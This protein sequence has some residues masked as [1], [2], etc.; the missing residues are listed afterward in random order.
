MRIALVVAPPIYAHAGGSSPPPANSARETFAR[1]GVRATELPTVRE[2]G[3]L[4]AGAAAQIGRGDTVV[5][6]VSGV[7]V[8]SG[9][10]I[11]LRLAADDEH[12]L[13]PLRALA[14]TVFARAPDDALFVVDARHDGPA[15][16]A[17]FAAEHVDAIATALD[18]R[19]RG[20]S[21][22]VGV[23][24][25]AASITAPNLWPFTRYVLRALEEPSARDDAGA[26][27]IS[28]VYRRVREM[29]ETST[30]VQSF[31]LV[32]GGIDFVV[33]DPPRAH[34][35]MPPAS[36]SISQR[37][38]L[39]PI[40]LGADEAR[41][42]ED[43]DEALD[44]YKKALM[45]VGEEDKQARATIYADIGEVKLAQ[46][47]PREAELNFEKALAV[48]PSHRR[49]IE[50]LIAIATEARDLRRAV[51][52]RMKLA[53]SMSGDEKSAELVRIAEVLERDLND[54]RAALE[55]IEKALEERPHNAPLLAR[56]CLLYEA[57]HRWPKVIET[58]GLIADTLPPGRDRASARFSQADVALGRIRD[59]SLGL[60][61]L[62]QSLED[63]PTHERA[64][65]AI[66]A[67]HT[68]RQEWQA[69]D[70]L[71]ATMID[72]FAKSSDKERAWDACRKL[73]AIR[74]DK[75]HDIDG[76]RE[77]FVG[78]L[79]C[80][81]TDEATRLMLAELHLSRGDE[82]SAIA[83]YE[84]IASHAPLRASTYAR[85]YAL[86]HKAGRRDR[87]WLAAQALEELH[88]ADV[89]QQ[90]FLDQYR[91][92]GQIRP[93]STLDDAAWD[94]WLRAPGADEVV[95]GILGAIVPAAV[96]MR[97]N[98]LRAQKLLAALDP[99]RLQP[100][101]STVSL[102]RTFA[103]A[104]QVLGVTLPDLY[105]VDNVPGGIAAVRVERPSTALGPDVLKGWSPQELAFLAG[106]H[107]AYY[108]PE[109]YALVFF[110]SVAD[111]SALF[112]AA[113][114]IA[115][116]DVPV[117]QALAPHV[118]RMRAE[119]SKL[120]TNQEKDWLAVSVKALDARDGRV[121]LGA[122]IKS[123]EL[124]A[125]RAG[126]LLAGDLQIAAK[127]IGNEQR[128]IAELSSDDRRADLLAFCASSELSHLREKLGTTARPSLPPPSSARA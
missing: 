61:L 11:A 76:A 125:C 70:A 112:L 81:P 117:P 113:I 68:A 43:W 35:S 49:S 53:M 56:L 9:R 42:R 46:S 58:L 51:A 92:D 14:D 54:P 126:L 38:H 5:V 108:R 28:G 119:L 41:E 29:P 24:A 47:K 13:L 16:D 75:L 116:P 23:R 101:T 86:H 93:S 90:I 17:I 63:D 40:I 85:L 105:V 21:A 71:Y 100:R 83:E 12:A 98:E 78:A 50:R 20:W 107:L 33:A 30:F 87:Q 115:M 84:T 111:L 89:E 32:K 118:A 65:H 52:F 102:V 128:G 114:K 97:T 122:W 95:T 8:P 2:L 67:V 55:P 10:E 64:L 3:A 82:A 57:L 34:E 59:E 77:A 103:W 7:T 109:H 69:L 88:A 22:L 31:T 73:A 66:V 99:T 74:R 104:S 94:S 80:K 6:H 27:C 96:K 1:L 4:F 123:V 15:G 106:R 37:P 26:L 110:P 127:I 48:L 45:L 44:A 39:M 121:D 19:V 120:A 60:K 18:V 25:E 79:A 124:T 72:R 62:E 36:I 91:P